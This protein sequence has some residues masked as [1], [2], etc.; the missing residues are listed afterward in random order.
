LA[1]LF[2][3]AITGAHTPACLL[4]ANDPVETVTPPLGYPIDEELLM[5][6]RM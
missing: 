1:T 2:L 6:T 5:G 3:R 4:A